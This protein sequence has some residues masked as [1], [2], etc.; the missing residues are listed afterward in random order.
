MEHLLFE[1][2][3]SGLVWSRVQAMC[4]VFRALSL[5]GFADYVFIIHSTEYIDMLSELLM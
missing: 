1:Y 2:A 4:S 3:V 5:A